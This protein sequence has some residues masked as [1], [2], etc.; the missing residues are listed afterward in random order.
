MEN[1]AKECAVGDRHVP[2]LSVSAASAAGPSL[3]CNIQPS[4][5]GNFNSVCG[6]SEAAN[7]YGVTYLVQGVTGTPSYA[8]T[9]PSSGRVADGCTSTSDTC[10]IDVSAVGVDRRL[11]ASVVVPHTAPT[12]DPGICSSQ[13]GKTFRHT[14][15]W[16]FVTIK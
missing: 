1:P 12:P 14:P 16:K 10:V 8:W 2:A 11:T 6:T 5:N 13:A 15:Q 7:T 3:G 4:G 9:V